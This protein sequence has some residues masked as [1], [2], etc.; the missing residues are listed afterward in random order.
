MAENA[1]K[2][3]IA[4]TKCIMLETPEMTERWD[5]VIVKHVQPKFNNSLNA[6]G[7]TPNQVFF[8]LDINPEDHEGEL[9]M[10][11]SEMQFKMRKDSKAV[12]EIINKFR[13]P[14]RIA[15]KEAHDKQTFVEES[16]VKVGDLVVIDQFQKRPKFED[17]H[18]GPYQV[19][20]IGASK[21]HLIVD[22]SSPTEEFLSSLKNVKPYVVYIGH[23]KL[24]KSNNQKL[25]IFP[26]YQGSKYNKEKYFNKTVNSFP[27]EI[28]GYD[29]EMGYFARYDNGDVS[30]IAL[31]KDIHPQLLKNFEKKMKVKKL[32]EEHKADLS[33]FAVPEEVQIPVQNQNEVQPQVEAQIPVQNQNEVQP[34]VE[35]QILVQNQNEAPPQVEVQLPNVVI[36]EMFPQPEN[37][38]Q[39]RINLTHG[40]KKKF[41]KKKVVKSQ[42]QI[43]QEKQEEK[44]KKDTRN[45]WKQTNTKF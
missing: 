30:A 27:V 31:K 2:Q 23:S 43:Q 18:N 33:A 39:D 29:E 9:E 6:N 7:F 1:N 10:S 45:F 38:N 42:K 34:Q 14:R 41:S 3:I 25:P 5:E 40:N 22:I 19:I 44:E 20:G 15:Q 36:S 26:K 35:A 21:T 37:L 17:V 12:Q 28:L 4:I 24:F 11:K 8:G 16:K 13:I 32:V